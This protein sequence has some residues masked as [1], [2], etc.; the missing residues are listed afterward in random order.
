M[1]IEKLLQLMPDAKTKLLSAQKSILD[2]R[3]ETKIDTP[4]PQF[5]GPF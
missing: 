3:G 5:Q 1:I 2:K 4:N